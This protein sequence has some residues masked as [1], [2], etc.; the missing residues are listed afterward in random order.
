MKRR[1]TKPSTTLV[2][3]R[4]KGQRPRIRSVKPTWGNDSDLLRAG[5]HARILSII[6]IT[7]ADDLGN[8]EWSPDT[9]GPMYF[10]FDQ[11]PTRVIE[12]AMQKLTPWFAVTYTEKGRAYYHINNFQD[13]QRIDKKQPPK[14]P[15]FTGA[16]LPFPEYSRNDPGLFLDKDRIG[17][18]RIGKDRNLDLLKEIHVVPFPQAEKEPTF[19]LAPVAPKPKRDPMGES[20]QE[21][22]E[23]WKTV[24]Q[25]NSNT[26]LTPKRKRLI[27][28]RLKEGY[29]LDDIKRAIDGCS[30]DAFSMGANDRCKPFNDIEL[31][32]RSGEKLEGFRDALDA[33]GGVS[34]PWVPPHG[35][36]QWAERVL[37]KELFPDAAPYD[38]VSWDPTKRGWYHYVNLPRPG[39]FEKLELAHEE[40]CAR[41]EA[42]LAELNKP[43]GSVWQQN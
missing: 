8:G 30:Q 32:C 29:T 20:I 36:E 34:K 35:M 33:P 23:Y 5:P 13:H 11:E 26:L 24:M 21:V 14:F 41:F 17:K 16:C 7:Q 1:S 28:D 9:M 15:V 37:L 6:L 10:P 19:A 4:Q 2:I 25:K 40:I 3:K 27:R 18:D 43:K 38:S 42:Y 22:F 12:H 39:R 31:I